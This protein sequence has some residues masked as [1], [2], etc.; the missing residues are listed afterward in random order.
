M[1]FDISRWEKAL[2]Q[3]ASE[4]EKA[5]REA[6]GRCLTLLEQYFKNK[7][8]EKVYLTGSIILEGKFY[9]FSDVDIA[10]EGLREQY[11]KTLSDLEGLV[12]REV[13]LIELEK[14]PF[15]EQVEKSGKRI[16]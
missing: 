5:R 4:R 3:E 8:V 2:H 1:K 15:R 7:K 16:R 6:L 14:C 12:E 11:L 9:A 10:V 13:D